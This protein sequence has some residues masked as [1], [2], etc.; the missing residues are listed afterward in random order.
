MCDT[1][2]HVAS[3]EQSTNIIGTLFSSRCM[4]TM[5]WQHE[6]RF[7]SIYIVWAVNIIHLRSPL[8]FSALQLSPFALSFSGR[9]PYTKSASPSRLKKMKPNKIWQLL[10]Q[11][12]YTTSLAMCI[13]TKRTSKYSRGRYILSKLNTNGSPKTSALLVDTPP[14][15]ALSWQSMTLS[16][17]NA[18]RARPSIHGR[19]K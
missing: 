7:Y 15:Q 8:Y 12:I 10:T 18:S 4:F 11:A 19:R 2:F 13:V 6:R 16:R 3:M 5:M 9:R 1:T 14:L 17:R